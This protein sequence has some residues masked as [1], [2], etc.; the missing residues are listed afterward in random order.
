MSEYEIAIEAISRVVLRTTKD[1]YGCVA[2]AKKLQN[3][4]D[5]MIEAV[6]KE[7]T[8]EMVS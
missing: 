4:I 6:S 8:N 5:K 2:D 3:E 1:K 7:S